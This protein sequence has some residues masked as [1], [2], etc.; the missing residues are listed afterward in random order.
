MAPKRTAP[1]PSA[2]TALIVLGMQRSGTSAL[3]G[4]LPRMGANLPRPASWGLDVATAQADQIADLENKF[5]HSS[6]SDNP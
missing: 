3:A 4:A 6:S 2:R 5:R 1:R